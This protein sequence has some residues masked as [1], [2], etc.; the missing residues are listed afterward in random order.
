MPRPYHTLSQSDVDHF[1]AKGH[2]VV[3]NCF[4]R[5]LADE[6]TALAFKRLG[7]DPH[8][9]STWTEQRV[10]L[11][12]VNHVPIREL[13]PKAWGALCDLAGGA[14]RISGDSPSWGDGLICNFSLRADEPWQPPS[15]QVPGWHKD[16]DFFRHF[17][18]SPEQGL[19]TI[20]I[21]SD[22]KAQSG[23]TF[24]ACD[25]VPHVARRLHAHPEG[26]LPGGFGGLIDE[27]RDFAE[28]T[29]DVG[30]V[31]IIHPFV[32]HAAS[33]NP[34]GRA[35]FITN[36]PVSLKE[37]MNFN[38]ANPDDFSPVELGVLRGLGLERLDFQITQQRERLVPERIARQKKM[39]EEQQRR[40]EAAGA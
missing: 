28:I 12:S 5:T 9:R 22:I 16:G 34:S 15:A 32:L 11:P 14:E 37:P 40:L 13:A 17:L 3:R 10:H 36:P 20:V 27:C 19:L 18:D 8:D 29:G 33:Q 2:V 38:R 39:M 4:E 23:G 1:L 21:W 7:Y 30:D 24:V 25:S 26:L 6:W 35:R 31:V